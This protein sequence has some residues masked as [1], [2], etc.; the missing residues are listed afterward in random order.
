MKW[1]GQH[2]YDLI[3]RF[4]EDVYVEKSDLYVYDSTTVGN[5][6]ISLGSS[7]DNRLEIKTAYNSGGQTLDSVYFN[8]YTTSGSAN[9]GRYIFQVDEVEFCRFL[10]TGISVTGNVSATDADAR[11]TATDTTTSSAT[12]GGTLRLQSDDGAVMGDT[13]RL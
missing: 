8:S 9:D 5:P 10:D 1:I 4:R 2:I 13:Y 7:A 11:L 6:T 12:Q 3:S